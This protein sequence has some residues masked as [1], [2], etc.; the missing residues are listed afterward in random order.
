MAALV[1]QALTL[2]SK[3][4]AD[5]RERPRRRPF[6]V[7]AGEAKAAAVAR[8][9]EL[10]LRRQVVRRAPEVRAGDAQRIEARYVVLDV[11]GGADQPDAVFLFPPLVHADAVL[12]RKPGLEL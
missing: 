1:D 2:F 7:D 8:T 5:A 9:F 12:G 11:V 6:E 3:H 4:D 10:V